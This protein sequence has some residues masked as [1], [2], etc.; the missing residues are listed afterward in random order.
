MVLGMHLHGHTKKI[1]IPAIHRVSSIIKRA[2]FPPLFICH[3]KHESR[4]LSSRFWPFFIGTTENQRFFPKKGKKSK[5]KHFERKG[6]DKKIKKSKKKHSAKRSQEKTK[7]VKKNTSREESPT[8]EKCEIK[9][10]GKKNHLRLE[11]YFLPYHAPNAA[12]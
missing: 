9:K 5:K 10:N 4:I 2:I 1:K 6:A 3:L 11:S 7:K 12:I 8:R